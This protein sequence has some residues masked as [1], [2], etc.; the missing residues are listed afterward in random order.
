MYCIWDKQCCVGCNEMRLK[1][2]WQQMQMSIVVKML[3]CSARGRRFSSSLHLSVTRACVCLCECMHGSLPEGQLSARQ[4]WVCQ[5]YYRSSFLP[6]LLEMK[7]DKRLDLFVTVFGLC[8]A[9][10]FERFAAKC[11]WQLAPETCRKPNRFRFTNTVYWGFILFL[12]EAAMNS[13]QLAAV[14]IVKGDIQQ[15]LLDGQNDHVWP[16]VWTPSSGCCNLCDYVFI[17][18]VHIMY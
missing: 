9:M 15:L 1:A 10:K 18:A 8:A 14:C 13:L 7:Q 16:W 11:L 3:T 12:Y 4:L 6:G 17:S 5:R 2:L